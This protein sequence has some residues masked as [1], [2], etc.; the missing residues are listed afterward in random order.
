MGKASKIQQA[1]RSL[2]FQVAAL[3]MGQMAGAS[4]PT[5]AKL[6]FGVRSALERVEGLT[7]DTT[8]VVQ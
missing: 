8:G 1:E 5:I 7:V 6:A 4:L 2:K 3:A